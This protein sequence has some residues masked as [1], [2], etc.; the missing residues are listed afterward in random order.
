MMNPREP[1]PRFL[2]RGSSIYP[3]SM[4]LI[5]RFTSITIIYVKEPNCGQGIS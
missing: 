1:I 4:N 3:K 5:I 2:Q